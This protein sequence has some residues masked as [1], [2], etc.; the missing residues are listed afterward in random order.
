MLRSISRTAAVTTRKETKSAATESPWGQPSAA[1]TRPSSTATVPNE[2][3]AEVER[4]REQRRSSTGAQPVARRTVAET[5]IRDDRDHDLEH[6]PG[7]STSSRSR[8]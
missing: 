1:T 6:P 3:A 5:S 7:A 4:V 8:R 2:V